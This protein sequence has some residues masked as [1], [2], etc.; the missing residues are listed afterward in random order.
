MTSRCDTGRAGGFTLIEMLAVIAI[1]G[2]ALALVVAYRAPMSRGLDLRASASAV[3][4]GLRLT[5]SEA[6]LKNRSVTF[7]LDLV[8]HRFRAG[9]APVQEL[10]PALAIDLLTIAGERRPGLAA[11]IRFNPD[12]SSTGGRI[13]L[14]DGGRAIVVGVDWLTGRVS[15]ADASR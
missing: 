15:I 2:A 13:T 12:G 7:D 8:A 3:A 5:R 14:A 11:D 6:I 9:S 1:L 10:P 4:T